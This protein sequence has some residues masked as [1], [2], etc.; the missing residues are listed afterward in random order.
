MY[1]FFIKHR[2]IKAALLLLLI[3]Y[4]TTAYA[5]QKLYVINIASSQGGFSTKDLPKINIKQ[6]HRFYSI[7]LKTNNA[8]WNR[9]R[10]GFFTSKAEALTYLKSVTT[11]YPDAFLGLVT[12]REVEYSKTAEIHSTTYPALYLLLRSSDTL[13]TSAANLKLTP[14][15]TDSPRTQKSQA[16][17][18]PVVDNYYIIN[19]KTASSLNDFDS[20][21]K[22]EEIQKHALYITELEID[23]RT[24]YQYR[25]GFF[26]DKKLAEITLKNLQKS[27]PLARII[28]ISHAEKQLATDRIRAFS[29]ASTALAPRP[30]KIPPA[31]NARELYPQLIDKGTKA[32][33]AKDYRSAI[34]AFTKLLSYPENSYSMDAQELL[35]FA[36]ELNNQ[37]A[38]ARQTY[39]NYLSLYPESR[40]AT[41]VTQRLA[42]LITARSS[43]PRDLHEAKAKSIIP[44]WETFGSISQFYRRDTSSLDIDTETETSV[45]NIT[46]TR[47]NLSEIDTLANLNARYRSNDYELRSRFTGGYIYDLQS[48]SEGNDVPINELYFDALSIEHNASI[49]IGRQRSNKGGVFG[50]FDGIDTGYQMTDWVKMNLTTGYLVP[51]TTESANK[52]EFFTSLRADLGTFFNAWDFSLYYM[53]QANGDIT[54]REAIG[55]EFR[56]FHPQRSLFG[57]VDHDILFD[58]TNTILLNGSWTT[59]RKTSFNAT[60]DLRQSPL[61]TT[62]NALQGQT[63]TS[64]DDMLNSF[65]E[66]EV[67]QIAQ[68][69][70]SSVKTF[71]LGVSQPLSDDYTLNADITSS[72]ISATDASAGVEAFP[73]TDTEYY[74][75]SQLIGNHVFKQNDSSIIGVNYNDTTTSK[76]T[77]LRWNYRIPVSQMLRFNPRI[78]IAERDNTDDTSQ[79]ILG[80]AFKMDYRWNR[81]TSFEFEFSSESSDKTLVSGQEK[82]DIYFLNMGYHYTF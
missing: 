53:K 54:G 28:R 69:R 2:L 32:L 39:E 29:T 6:S 8:I 37:I 4:Q 81:R 14:E 10:L 55:S 50:R 56:Y 15:K 9:L 34:D 13:I 75:S 74:F 12:E 38:Y 64:I 30:E 68:D 73:A 46:D 16:P 42:S 3:C 47:V 79:S 33:S 18:E 82:N 66:T 80:L 78:S 43:S 36:Y 57:L 76:T 61:L 11:Q 40:G 25:M 19:L 7:K 27:Y 17:Q 52:D 62:Q 24:W 58:K 23:G 72:K 5:E 70:T 26:I 59:D 21:I 77:S 22:Q 71:I 41:R 20:I 35:G 45:I 51:N 48:D 60:I 31:S 63:F 49:R 65:T 67:L 44:K 1:S